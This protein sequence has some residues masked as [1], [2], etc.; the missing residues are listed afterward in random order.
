M[1]KL[2]VLLFSLALSACAAIPQPPASPPATPVAACPPVP[3]CPPVPPTAVVPPP[4]TA[5]ALQPST[6]DAISG[7]RDDDLAQAWEAFRQS[8]A[9]LQKKDAAWQ[10]TCAAAG[11]LGKPGGEKLRG[12]FEQYFTPYLVTNPD[13]G[14]D[15]LITGYYEPLLAG[16][17]S[18]SKR[19]PHPLYAVPDDL[20]TV[21]LSALYPEL[22]S[23]RLRGRLQGNK[24]VPYY[25]RAE[26]DN[27]LAP[28][29]G[30]ELLWVDDAV[31]LFFL[32][33]QGSGRVKLDN[34]ETVRIGYADQNG[35]PYKSIG[36]ALVERGELPLEKASMQGIKDWGKQNPDKLAEL[37][38]LNASY[39][40]FRELPNNGNGPLGA[41][42]VPLTAGRSLAVDP[43]SIP[44]G[45]PVFL[46]TTWPNS[47]KPLQRLMLAQDTGGAIRG[48]VRA[49]FFWGFG[50]EAGKEA[51]AMKQSGRMWVLLPKNYPL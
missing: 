44:L 36:K 1:P 12:F 22:K 2:L 23:L 17:R 6:W 46:S 35:H 19:Y 24:L 51:G 20:V 5:P 18:R 28:L 32:Q 30:R 45:A 3:F 31:E 16:G 33:I 26:I 40:F 43:R 15:G 38:N 48:A 13:G 10:E 34:G 14:N 42:G 39:V 50:K 8:C 7:W 11:A 49:D 27:G 25:T 47:G 4:P 37:L 21:D 9:A 29:K 41:L